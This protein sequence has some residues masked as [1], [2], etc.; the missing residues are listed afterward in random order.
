VRIN[1]VLPVLA[2]EEAATLAGGGGGVTQSNGQVNEGLVIVGTGTVSAEP[3]MATVVFGVELQGEDP[4][5]LMEEARGKALENAAARAEQMAEGLGLV[6]GSPLVVV[7]CPEWNK[8]HPSP[9][10]ILKSN[11]AIKQ[12]GE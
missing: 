7:W 12:G 3:E 2:S 8:P 5:P 9:V 1:E 6:L 10:T 4:E 11:A